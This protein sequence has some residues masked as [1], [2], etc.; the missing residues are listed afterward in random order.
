MKTRECQRHVRDFHSEKITLRSSCLIFPQT[1]LPSSSPVHCRTTSRAL[2]NWKPENE[3]WLNKIIHQ[4]RTAT[5]SRAARLSIRLH[6]W[7][8]NFLQLLCMSRCIHMLSQCSVLRPE[9]CGECFSLVFQ[10]QAK[11]RSDMARE[12][13]WKTFF[14]DRPIDVQWKLRER[15]KEKQ[16]KRV[17]QHSIM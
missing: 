11:A 3:C 8:N 16:K 9:L 6:I 7:E 4:Q 10:F 14:Y 17:S 2:V 12:E 15:A 1:V 5:T 13:H